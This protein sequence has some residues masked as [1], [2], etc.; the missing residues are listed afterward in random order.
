[1][2]RHLLIAE[3]DAPLRQMM[4]WEFQDLGYRVT[5]SGCCSDTLALSRRACFDVALL[6]YNLPDGFGTDLVLTLLD[7]SPGLP[8]V[9]YSGRDSACRMRLESTVVRGLCQFVCKP[10]GARALHQLFDRLLAGEP[11]V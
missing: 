7:R 8:I 2:P 11:A 4:A 9:I 5:V 10:V 1:M 3:D 6:D